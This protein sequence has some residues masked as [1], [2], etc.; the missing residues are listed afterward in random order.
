MKND[1]NSA[2]VL[3][4]MAIYNSCAWHFWHRILFVIFP[5]IT[6]YPS[7]TGL[8]ALWQYDIVNKNYEADEQSKSKFSLVIKITIVRHDVIK[9]FK[10]N[11]D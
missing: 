3:H 7:I 4:T 11:N 2:H 8:E 10:R 1:N 6:M 9:F 5:V